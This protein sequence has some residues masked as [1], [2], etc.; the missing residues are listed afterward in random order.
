MDINK[1]WKTDMDDVF[2]LYKWETW[3][4]VEALTL[5]SGHVSEE[6]LIR[7]SHFEQ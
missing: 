1:D 4:A 6:I 2:L 7:M 5:M 3:E